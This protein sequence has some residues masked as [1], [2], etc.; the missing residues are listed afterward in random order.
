MIC[1]TITSTYKTRLTTR[2][3]DSLLARAGYVNACRKIK[4]VPGVT[5][6]Q[7]LLLRVSTWRRCSYVQEVFLR[8]G[9]VPTCRRYF[10]QKGSPSVQEVC[11]QEVSTYYR[12]CRNF[13]EN[14]AFAS[15]VTTCRRCHHVQTDVGTLRKVCGRA[16][17][18]NNGWPAIWWGSQV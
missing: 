8:A 6:L 18:E 13:L 7:K 16:V 12:K 9:G 10:V 15:G 3:I 5:C 1:L 4:H 17:S 2:H 11:L 14:L